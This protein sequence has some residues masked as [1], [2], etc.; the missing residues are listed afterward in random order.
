[1]LVRMADAWDMIDGDDAIRVA[2]LTGA[3]GHFCAGSDLKLMAQP[4][5]TTSGARASRPSPSC[6]GSRSCATT[7]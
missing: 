2:I 6:T 7:G 3:G 5:P 4:R 1:M